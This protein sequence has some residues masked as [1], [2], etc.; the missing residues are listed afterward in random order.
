MNP[1]IEVINSFYNAIVSYYK[2]ANGVIFKK[3]L[4]NWIHF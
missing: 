4:I 1:Y 2:T 3:V